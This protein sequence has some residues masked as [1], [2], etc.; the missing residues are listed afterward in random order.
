ML[1]PLNV[2]LQNL[3][4]SLDRVTTLFMA[5]CLSVNSLLASLSHFSTVKIM[6]LSDKTVVLGGKKAC[7]QLQLYD[8][9][10]LGKTYQISEAHFFSF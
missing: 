1:A 3:L 8:L 9:L 7:S 5:T 10:T 2:A 4:P 6:V